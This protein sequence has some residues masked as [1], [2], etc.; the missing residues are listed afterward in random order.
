MSGP[1][2]RNPY[3]TAAMTGMDWPLQP[4]YAHLG[5]GLGGWKSL[6][7]ITPIGG[8]LLMARWLWFAVAAFG[9]FRE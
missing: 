3:P 6:G 9:A 4:R 2:F 7:P 5:T 8:L 1:R